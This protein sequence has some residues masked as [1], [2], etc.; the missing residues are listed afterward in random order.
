MSCWP[1][2]G[3]SG[4]IPWAWLTPAAFSSSGRPARGVVW[5]RRRAGSLPGSRSKATRWPWQCWGCLGSGMGQ[6]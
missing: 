2:G 4:T 5:G 3:R 1:E 6:L